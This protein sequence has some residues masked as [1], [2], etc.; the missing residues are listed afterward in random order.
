MESLVMAGNDLVERYIA[1]VKFW[2]PSN[3]AEDVGAELADD[4]RS[5]ID[6]AENAKD[7]PL[8]EDE[9]ADI[10]KARGKPMA[11]AARYQPQRRLIGPELFPLYIF[12]LKIVA[13]ICFIP[14]V[15]AWFS[16]S[17]SGYAGAVPGA[18]AAPFNSLLVSFAI[19]TL[20]FAAIEHKGI[21]ITKKAEFNPKSLRPV[22]DKNRIPRSDSIAEIIGPMIGIGFYLAGY[23]SQTTYHFPGGGSITVAP[24]WIV[25][26]QIIIGLAVFDIALGAI[27]LFKP[28]WSGPRVV[29]QLILNL[30][31]TAAFCWLFQSHLVRAMEGVPVDAVSQFQMVSDKLA[32]FALPFFGFIVAIIVAKALW[33]LVLTLKPKPAV[34]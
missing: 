19:V 29:A 9:I 12:V 34:A 17:L 25:F 2:L 22:I 1:A 23:F 16:W 31:K 26:W 8:T 13:A 10:L 27:N 11:V 30:A 20:V 6:D 21:D 32:E 14:P 15:V 7:R 33:R 5:E 18:L 4:I 24:E 3:I 28:Y